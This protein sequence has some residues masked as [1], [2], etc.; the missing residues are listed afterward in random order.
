[1][2]SQ[3]RHRFNSLTWV[4]R[5]IDRSLEAARAAVLNYLDD[6]AQV[7]HLHRALPQI[8][9]VLGT[10]EVAE[11]SGAAM[12]AQECLA[13][14]RQV[15]DNRVR[16]PVEAC[17]LVVRALIQLPDYLEYIQSGRED[18]PLVLVSIL[19]D[20]RAARDEELI[21]DNIVKI[22]NLDQGSDVA[23]TRPLTHED[24][25][26][27]AHL[28][29]HVFQLGLLGWYRNKNVQSNLKK[30]ALVCQRLRHASHFRASKRL[31]WVSEAILE[32]LHSRVL[33]PSAAIKLVL[34][35]IDRQIKLL[36]EMGEQRFAPLIP[37]EL[38]RSLLYYVAIAEPGNPVVDAV[39]EAYFL[40]GDLPSP[41][42][43]SAA[44]ISV[45]GQNNA[46]FRSVAKAVCEDVQDLKDQLEIFGLAERKTIDLLIPVLPSLRRLAE[47]LGM[48]GLSELREAVHARFE[49][50]ERT[51]DDRQ[52]PDEAQSEALAKTLLEVE[53]S[54]ASYGVG[55]RDM[56]VT[57]ED[58]DSDAAGQDKL[59]DIEYAKTRAVAIR[60]TL[61][62][63]EQCKT[64]IATYV[65]SEASD[66]LALAP[67]EGSL[68]RMQGALQVLE[69]DQCA[70]LVR[71]FAPAMQRIATHERLPATS[72][73]ER[74]ADVVA[75]IEL[76][77]ESIEVSG[78][79]HP[80]YLDSGRLALHA[81]E[82][83]LDELVEQ[84]S[85]AEDAA[86]IE[87]AM[88]LEPALDDALRADEDLLS[89]T[90]I[91][92]LT[93]EFDEPLTDLGINATLIGLDAS[94]SG[95]DHEQIAADDQFEGDLWDTS[96]MRALAFD[97]T[98][99]KPTVDAEAAVVPE[100]QM[101]PEG[102]PA[103]SPALSMRGGGEAQPA[104][105]PA[106]TDPFAGLEVL[107]SDADPEFLD[108]FA[109]ELGEEIQ[110]LNAAIGT[111]ADNPAEREALTQIRRAFH[112]I[113]GSSRLI[114]AQVI[115]EF[116]WNHEHLLNGAMD[117]SIPVTPAL[118]AYVQSGIAL[119]PVLRDQLL[120]RERP[121]AAVISH[122]ARIDTVENPNAESAGT[123]DH[124]AEPPET[125]TEP[126]DAAVSETLE[127]ARDE[128][129]A[130]S[131]T[132]LPAIVPSP[133]SGET[134]VPSEEAAR[135]E[136]TKPADEPDAHAVQASATTVDQP[137][138]SVV[139]PESTESEAVLAGD[140]AVILASAQDVAGVIE[141]TAKP[142]D[143]ALLDIFAAEALE[144]ISQIRKA[145]ARCEM[146]P[147]LVDEPLL[148]AAHTLNGAARTAAL[149]E[150][151]E[152]AKD[153]ERLLTLK[154]RHALVLDADE[155]TLL[156]DFAGYVEHVI[157]ALQAST[158]VPQDPT[159]QWRAHEAA[160]ALAQSPSLDVPVAAVELEAQDSA[161]SPEVAND[162]LAATIDAPGS[163]DAPQ[164]SP[165]ADEAMSSGLTP[166]GGSS[167]PAKTWQEDGAGEQSAELVEV[168]LEE[169]REIL[170]SCDN[171]MARWQ[172]NPS[173]AGPL[174]ELR[175]ELHTLKGGARMAGIQ[176]LGDLSHALENVLLDV[177]EGQLN[178]DRELFDLIHTGLD[179]IN[180][181]AALIQAHKPVANNQ[182]LMEQLA[183]VR[184]GEN[185]SAKTL[186]G[187]MAQVESP[188]AAAD[189]VRTMTVAAPTEPAT[190]PSPETEHEADTAPGEAVA[191][192]VAAARD[193]V[194]IR[195]DLLDK[196]VD[197]VGEVNVFQSRLEQQVGGFAFNL[198][199]L[200]QTIKRLGA[201]LRRLEVETEAQIV[202]RYDAK[203][204]P[205]ESSVYDKFDPLEL[206]RYSTMQQLARGLAESSNDLVNLHQILSE[207]IRALESLLRQQSRVSGDLQESLL[208]TRMSE[209]RV[210]VPRLR[211]VV[212]RAALELG[213]E[214]ELHVSGE[215]QPLDRKMLEGIMVPLEHML[216]NAV[217]HGIELPEHR[218]Q[219]GK[220]RIGRI[221]VRIAREGPEVVI[222]VS[223]D[224]AGI[225]LDAV[226][227]K[228]MAVCLIDGSRELTDAEVME[229]ILQ[230]GFSTAERVSQL[231]GRGVG[232]DVVQEQVRRLN[233]VLDIQS[234]PGQGT[235]FR[236]H[237]PFTLAINQ[238]LLITVGT[239]LFA[240]P[241][242][243]IDSVVQIP[244]KVLNDKFAHRDPG[245]EYA[246]ASY[247]LKLLSAVLERD[248]HH[249]V[250]HFERTMPVL[251]ARTHD[252]AVGF[253][254]DQL[255]G[256][257]E[258]VV[259]SIGA[260]FQ[261]VKG[262]S[263][264]TI[265]GDGRVVLILDMLGLL[266]S[267]AGEASWAPA[268]V[269]KESSVG[270]ERPTIMVVDDSITI[271]KVTARMLERHNFNVITAKDGM[272]AIAQLQEVR[273][274]MMLLDIEMPRMDGYELAAHIRSMDTN[275]ELPIIMITSRTGKKHRD[276]ALE[277]GVNRFLGKPYQDQ[278]LI[279]NIQAVF[280]EV[281][282]Q[283]HG[284]AAR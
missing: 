154:Y 35:K 59:R 239:E 95:L 152:T 144:H 29:R 100:P 119:L 153:L 196:M 237:L 61:T 30:M 155:V 116:A 84:T 106:Q 69:L 232:M 138:D 234:T 199:E 284:N 190:T 198:Q 222:A 28:T 24:L 10:L 273:P 6:T 150:I 145:C 192:E 181:M 58:S 132:V 25:Q 19:N 127:R 77:L 265:L 110:R 233:G 21:S 134:A 182:P 245:I 109:E 82:R 101:A 36:F 220:P 91:I 252:R 216:R 31:W 254:V 88:L 180:Q 170:D 197:N 268:P 276:R 167:E 115:G 143:T 97:E 67:I 18:I 219:A 45:S 27:L 193:V 113:K 257:R 12:L 164:A 243:A 40:D 224:G 103:G 75:S 156:L 5:E 140:E 96:L 256:N 89:G 270:T 217:A 151:Y 168:F 188:V 161:Q 135:S 81:L 33:A 200:D 174:A 173:D 74:M 73:V 7:Q 62:E 175:R 111:W 240:V 221:Q 79:P 281:G 71:D 48:L 80:P 52:I 49:E 183:R 56:L 4:K 114:G 266:R 46:L 130:G 201:Q 104:D 72:A 99:A 41:E 238:A 15:A 38:V 146:G 14:I 94:A 70:S 129:L 125:L 160:E 244:A 20:L 117:G 107:T 255:I 148:R 171:I 105:L 26:G 235:R 137:S 264:A 17:K 172:S 37:I 236:I 122:L 206:D 250:P 274:D 242:T 9:D 98:N 230:P 22:S 120:A 66:R 279:E 247:Q 186:A 68:Q 185:I 191:A 157:A 43:L 50:L 194:K 163:N 142:H 51:L 225:N 205:D 90:E 13:L 218:T 261:S 57:L 34:G 207:Q 228:A 209:F 176:V 8:K 44:R 112:T 283:A 118:I 124:P 2:D 179:Q 208:Q 251:L 147:A 204:D 76:Y 11:L 202:H 215:Q 260:L 166:R 128:E 126:A 3:I 169:C 278:V 63:L 54:M 133:L 78:E 121:N 241:L 177:V 262:I 210:M 65:K 39:R 229:L 139:A 246:G 226:R 267:V 165:A 269:R 178:P 189:P 85:V 53:A 32:A 187:I 16:R 141:E 184:R 272:D 1:M 86:A 93:E 280:K 159:L 282:Q 64:A 214:V 213:K 123:L 23:E 223:D 263:G 92:D 212:R 136:P 248:A 47:T 102:V 108:I 249:P 227:R 231:S 271:R 277:L 162:A 158:P 83:Q 203:I 195:A 149:P 60:E 275:R 131:A 211:R 55:A 258:I 253:V 42:A 259:K 87:E